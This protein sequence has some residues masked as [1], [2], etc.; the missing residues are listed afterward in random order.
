MF[1]EMLDLLHSFAEIMI[2]GNHIAIN[3]SPL[4]GDYPVH[5]VE[6]SNRKL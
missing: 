2:R 3:I 5:I 6:K 1:I 4:C